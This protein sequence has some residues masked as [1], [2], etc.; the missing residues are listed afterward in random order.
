MRRAAA[1][2]PGLL[3]AAVFLLFDYK[4]AARYFLHD[5]PAWT[6]EACVVLFIWIVFLA[7]ALLLR[8]TEQ[9]R[10]DLLYAP[11]SPRVRR[12]MA[13]LRQLLIGGL[14]L[15]CLPA[16]LD[17]LLF[18]WRERTPVLALRLDWTYSCFILFMA[19][20]IARAA[21]ALLGL[22]RSGWRARV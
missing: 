21:W 15:A 9:I 20:V 13:A 6:D 5:E 22:F 17:Y 3:F 16:T 1:L 7:N 4:I 19:A 10:F 8:D 11:A 14:F 18:L 12:V 2:L